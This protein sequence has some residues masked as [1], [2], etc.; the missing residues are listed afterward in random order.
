MVIKMKKGTLVLMADLE[1]ENF[2]RK[3]MLSGAMDGGL[4]VA[5]AGVPRHI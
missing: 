1:G 5:A 4:G 3:V 2:C